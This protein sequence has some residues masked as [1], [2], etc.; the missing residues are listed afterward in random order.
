MERAVSG[1]R[2]DY[3]A[4]PESIFIGGFSST[5]ICFL[6]MV[7]SARKLLSREPTELL[8][9]ETWN[10]NDTNILSSKNGING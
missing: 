6:S 3:D 10:S 1:A 9:T 8:Q 7:W 4:T 2:F 5:I